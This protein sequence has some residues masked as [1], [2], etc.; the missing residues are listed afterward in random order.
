MEPKMYGELAGWWPLLSAPAGYAEEAEIYRRLLAT[1]G[2]RAPET[3][4]ELG[5]GGGNN[6]SHLKAHFRLTL[7]DLSAGMLEVSRELNPGCE[8]V[9]GDMRTVRL[10]RV[11]DAV[12]VHDAVAYMTSEEDL[13]KVMDTAFAHCRPGGAALFAPDHLRENFRTGTDYGG[14]DGDGRA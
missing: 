9:Q 6:A 7:V 1:A 12:F 13:R 5:S 14:H 2:D 8:H 3:V 4:L 11:F 10:G